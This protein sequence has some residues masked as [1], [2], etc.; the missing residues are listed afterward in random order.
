MHLLPYV[1][2]DDLGRMIDYSQSSDGQAMAVNRVKIL[3]CPSEINDHP[4]AS[5][6]A[7]YPL[8]YLV[9]VGTWFVYDPLTGKTGDG[10]FIMNGKLRLTDIPDG[11]SNTLGMTEGKTFTPA[12]LDG[13]NPNVAS[14][15]IPT[16]PADVVANGG[17]L[18][19][20]GGHVEWIDAR[21]IQSG[22]TTTFPPNTEVLFSSAG[23]TYDVDFS[24]RREGKTGNVFT[25]SAVTARSFH[26]GGVNTVMMDGSVRFVTDSIAQ[27]TWR[28]LGTRSGGEVIADF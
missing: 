21:S 22:F 2:R 26:P 4:Q 16:V 9:N 6:T 13:A 15:P 24:S 20:V 7:P 23:V 8:N 27:A 5:A 14:A 18:K 25:Y 10:A 1:E 19:P 11:T 28:A 12:L 17:T 3:M